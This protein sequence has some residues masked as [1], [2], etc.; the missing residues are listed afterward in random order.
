MRI[1]NKY[2]FN[3][4]AGLIGKAGLASLMGISRT[5]LHRMLLE[6]HKHLIDANKQKIND[7]VEAL[8]D[9]LNSLKLK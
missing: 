3:E 7:A 4:L 6:E 1:D 8:V 9:V 5:Y 2:R